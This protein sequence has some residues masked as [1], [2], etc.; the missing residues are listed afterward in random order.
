MTYYEAALQVLRAA[1]RP[2]TTREIANVAI[3][4]G[5]I[6]SHGRTP[7]ASMSASLYLHVRKDPKLVK[8][9]IPAGKRAKRGSVRWV[10]I[11]ADSDRRP[12]L[13]Q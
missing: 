6:T 10:L 2:L 5:L 8:L 3:E 9:E 11:D 12:Y 13:V 1:Q 4:R 7:L